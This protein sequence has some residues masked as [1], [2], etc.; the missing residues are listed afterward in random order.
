MKYPRL[1]ILKKA[2][3]HFLT[4][5]RLPRPISQF[6]F[7]RLPTH[8]AKTGHICSNK[9]KNLL[10][11]VTHHRTIALCQTCTQR[12]PRG[13]LLPL[14]LPR[15]ALLSQYLVRDV[16][17]CQYL[18]R[19]AL[20][21]QYLLRDVL[22]SQYLPRGVLLSQYLPRGVLLSQYLPRGALLSVLT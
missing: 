22:L 20:L 11:L 8:Y 16:L 19:G 2:V 21:S 3:F 5:F 14:Y 7:R 1:R 6:D 15:G 17:L 9:P 12:A 4:L 10:S 18:P 13:A